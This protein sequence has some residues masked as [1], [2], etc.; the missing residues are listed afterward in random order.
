[1]LP[2]QTRDPGER[3]SNTQVHNQYQQPQYSIVLALRPAFLPQGEC[4]H[5]ASSGP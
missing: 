2:P 1:M 4:I 3:I 5:L